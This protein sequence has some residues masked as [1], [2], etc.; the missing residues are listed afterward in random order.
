MKGYNNKTKHVRTRTFPTHISKPYLKHVTPSL[1]TG[2]KLL[3]VDRR[4][5][6]THTGRLGLGNRHQGRVRSH[7]QVGG[8]ALGSSTS[9]GGNLGLVKIGEAGND[10]ESTAFLEGAEDL[11]I[12]SVCVSGWV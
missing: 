2:G 8:A 5:H 1:H 6:H 10:L 4:D 11:K 9:D 7:I 12:V 3:R